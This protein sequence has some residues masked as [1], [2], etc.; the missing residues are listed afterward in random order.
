MV[1]TSNELLIEADSPQGIVTSNLVL[2]TQY[3]FEPISP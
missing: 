2:A 3:L 1:N